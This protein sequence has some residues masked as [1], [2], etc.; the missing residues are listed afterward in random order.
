MLFHFASGGSV[1]HCHVILSKSKIDAGLKSQKM[2][3]FDVFVA[4]S[5]LLQDCNPPYFSRLYQADLPRSFSLVLSVCL[6][7][8]LFLLLPALSSRWVT[9]QTCWFATRFLQG[10]TW[11]TS[12]WNFDLKEKKKGEKMKGF[13][14]SLWP[15]TCTVV[16]PR[17]FTATSQESVNRAVEPLFGVTSSLEGPF[18]SLGKTVSIEFQW[19]ELPRDVS[20]KGYQRFPK[21][22]DGICMQLFSSCYFVRV[23]LVLLVLDTRVGVKWT[24]FWESHALFIF[25]GQFVDSF[26]SQNGANLMRQDC[27]NYLDVLIATLLKKGRFWSNKHKSSQTWVS[28]DGGGPTGVKC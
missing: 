2:L 26:R 18:A 15:P 23:V 9:T 8:W 1:V 27:W 3:L 28:K 17:C 16:F 11:G 13:W 19:F 21:N 25:L 22:H 10:A 20:V 24:C 14:C 5:R 4:C 12:L 6:V 7:P